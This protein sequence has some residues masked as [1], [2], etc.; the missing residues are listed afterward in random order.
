MTSTTLTLDNLATAENRQI[1]LNGVAGAVLIH[2]LKGQILEVNEQARQ[3][4]GVSETEITPMSLVTDLSSQASSPALFATYWQQAVAGQPQLF[5][6][7]ARRPSTGQIFEVE[8]HLKKIQLSTNESESLIITNVRDIHIRKQAEEE[9]NHLLA[10]AERRAVLLQ[11]ASEIGRAASMILDVPELIETAVNLIRDR[12]DFYYVGLFLVELLPTSEQDD[13]LIEWAVLKAGT[14]E[15]GKVQLARQHKLAVGGSSMI[16]WSVA[17][18]QAR[19]ALDVGEE[20]VRFKNPDLPLTRSEM[21][22]PLV[23][24]DEAL[25]ALTVQSVLES[26][27]SPEDITLLQT[28]ADQLANAIK[29]AQLFERVAQAQQEAEQRLQEMQALQSFS[30]ALAAT[31]DLA[32]IVEIF[33]HR[34]Q[35]QTD[36]GYLMVILVQ[37]G[38]ERVE[39]VHGVGLTAEELALAQTGLSQIHAWR[40]VF[41]NGQT[42]HGVGLGLND[43]EGMA[44]ITPIGVGK[45]PLGL[46]VA[47]YRSQETQ[48]QPEQIKLLRTFIDQA[49][50]AIDNAGRYAASQRVARRE[51]LLKEITTKVR[52]ST[53]VE[54]ILQTTVQEVSRAIGQGR[55]FIQLG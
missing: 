49:T 14:G 4:Y 31:L 17:N 52:A 21:A 35:Q 32:E 50:L 15:A 29:N 34:S 40:R 42:E 44:V 26:A 55:A 9:R 53:E 25:G 30:Q 37:N 46:V 43:N 7:Q 1:L 12:F 8:I 16:G 39:L 24:R 33:C 20:A 48:I 6:W 47:G 22:L 2:D 5:E 3:L 27:F 38:T 41:H 10:E 36:F 18:H 13:S 19:I 11:T 54:T 45:R 28:M 51:A 23:S